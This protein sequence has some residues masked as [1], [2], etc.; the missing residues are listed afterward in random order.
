MPSD[1]DAFLDRAKAYALRHPE[2][3]TQAEIIASMDPAWTPPVYIPPG[4]TLDLSRVRTA[5]AAPGPVRPAAPAATASSTPSAGTCRI[6]PGGLNIAAYRRPPTDLP[7][8]DAP[9][10][11]THGALS[12]TAS[13]RWRW[14]DVHGGFPQWQ[15]WSSLVAD[16]T[17]ASPLDAV[18]VHLTPLPG[19]NAGLTRVRTNGRETWCCVDVDPR[20]DQ[21]TR[22]RVLRHELGHLADVV[23][24]GH[25]WSRLTDPHLTADSERFAEHCETWLRPGMRAADVLAEARRFRGGRRA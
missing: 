22:T 21:E 9:P 2:D 4:R 14:I 10:P 17:A 18:T 15:S 20:T 25:D 19:P 5:A 11:K 23:A 13:G 6:P 1:R 16:L 3:R 24:A 7:G 12:F 8:E